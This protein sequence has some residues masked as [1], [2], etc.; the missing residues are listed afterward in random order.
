MKKKLLILLL[1]LWGC[2]ESSALSYTVYRRPDNRTSYIV[3]RTSDTAPTYQFQST[4]T[5]SSA[6]GASSYV[7]TTV[8]EPGSST[9]NRAPRKTPGAY[10]PWDEDGDGE[11]DPWNDDYNPSG[12]EIGQ[13]DTPVGSPWVML[14]F[15]VLYCLIRFISIKRNEE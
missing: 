1:V 8:Y 15:A 5:C 3:H 4:S 9:P 2:M 14:V 10:N 7:I 13:V 6:V 11:T 12:Q